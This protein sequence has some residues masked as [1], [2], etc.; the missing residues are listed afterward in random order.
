MQSA[1]RLHRVRRW[2]AVRRDSIIARTTAQPCLA[3]HSSSLSTLPSV[4]GNSLRV[5]PMA[6]S[7]AAGRQYRIYCEGEHRR[8]CAL[9]SYLVFHQVPTV[10]PAL[11]FAVEYELIVDRS[12]EGQFKKDL[13][14]REQWITRE[15]DH[16]RDQDPLPIMTVRGPTAFFRSLGPKVPKRPPPRAREPFALEPSL[17]RKSA[18]AAAEVSLPT[19]ISLS[20][21]FLRM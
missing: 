12:P 20:S 19:L 11:L 7:N 8:H 16:A 15:Q 21:V 10:N 4:L 2:H 13:N 17:D 3:Y 14:V 6:S 1:E 9:Q 18:R 5:G